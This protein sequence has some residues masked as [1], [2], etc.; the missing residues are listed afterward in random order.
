LGLTAERLL[1]Q[2]FA[3]EKQT[4]S[5][6]TLTFRYTLPSRVLLTKFDGTIGLSAYLC[7]LDE[8][9]TWALL[10]AKPRRPRPGVSV[11][12]QAEWGPAAHLGL[13]PGSVVDVT[14]TVT[15]SGKN[16]GFIRAE[17]RE[18]ETGDLIC[19]ASHTKYMP[20]SKP[21][22]SVLTPLGR[23]WLK[24]YSRCLAP[25]PTCQT[26]FE[27][28]D[29]FDSLDFVSHTQAHFTAAP[30]HH[31]ALGVGPVHGGCQ[32]I[33]MELVGRQVAMHAMASG[34]AY[35]DAIQIS[36]QSAA[37]VH[38]KL[39]A[40]V[41]SVKCNNSVSMRVV[42]VRRQDGAVVSEGILSF[43]TTFRSNKRRNK[44]HLMNSKSIT[45]RTSDSASMTMPSRSFCYRN[46]ITSDR[47][48]SNSSSDSRAT[49]PTG[50]LPSRLMHQQLQLH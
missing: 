50:A 25:E 16:L 35:L 42:L 33:L 32:A 45:Q 43:V 38:M 4:G 37:S 46:R 47:S 31:S 49:I 21:F 44:R 28:C 20:L 5:F 29:M 7:I 14:A 2:Q 34:M 9:T 23:L 15:K 13:F 12:L 17:V 36:Y 6:I 26:A 1:H 22:D 18:K 19:Y 3:L 40:E 30:K 10:L 11:S 8:V 41:L 27:M 24:V 48:I 39:E